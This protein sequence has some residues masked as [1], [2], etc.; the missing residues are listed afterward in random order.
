MEP[1]DVGGFMLSRRLLLKT[2]GGL[3]AWAVMGK[4]TVEGQTVEILKKPIPH[5]G[6]MLP[7][8]GLGTSRTFDVKPERAIG[9]PLQ[10]VMRLFV[11]RGGGLVDSSPMYGEA[12]RVVGALAAE[13]GIQKSLFL[14]TKVWTRGKQAGIRQMEG[15][16]RRMRSERIDLIQVHNLSDWRTQL[17]TLKEWK[18]SGRIRYLGVTHY[19]LSAFDE[20]AEI[21]KNDGLDFIEIP[22]SIDNRR[23][24]E[25]L[26]PIAADHGTAVI[27]H[28]PY[29]RGRLFRMVKG[30]PLP[31]WAEGGDFDI[32]SWGQF[33]LKYLISHPA[34]TCAIPAT[35]KPKHLMDNM[36]AAYGRLPD[37]KTR[38]RMAEY[39]ARL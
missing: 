17:D 30:R 22:Y 12:E 18:K 25:R 37:A 9:S 38:R 31:P 16:M 8:V 21:I 13:L 36:G 14:A 15:S 23:A 32:Q 11:E 24:E 34:C 19:A 28:T 39:M 35:T 27:A 2:L 33:F 6:E 1:K 4:P 10:E 3:G 29:G 20:V 26:L 7:V 5:S